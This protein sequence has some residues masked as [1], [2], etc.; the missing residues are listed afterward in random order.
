MCCI[1]V[2]SLC[3]S[4]RSRVQHGNEEKP[5]PTA[6]PLSISIISYWILGT[7]I[8]KISL[9][10]IALSLANANDRPLLSCEVIIITWNLSLRRNKNNKGQ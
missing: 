3:W 2:G 8:Y 1:C 9:E 6:T 4:M 7:I 5:T 10:I